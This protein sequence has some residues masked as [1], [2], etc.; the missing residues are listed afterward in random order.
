M[1]KK[2]WI[3]IILA[4]AL[5]V[6]VPLA[7][8]T[9]A[10]ADAAGVLYI[11]T[12]QISDV[13]RGWVDSKDTWEFSPASG[14][15][16]ATL[17][18]NNLTL[19]GTNYHKMSNN[20][21]AY[22]Y[23]T[24][25]NLRIVVNGTCTLGDDSQ[26]KHL[27]D[28][29]ATD[30]NRTTFGIYS[31]GSSPTTRLTITGKTSDSKLVIKTVDYSIRAAFLLV[32]S[33]TKIEAT[34]GIRGIYLGGLT[35][36][37]GSDFSVTSGTR[38]DYSYTVN[39]G[40]ET[41]INTGAKLTVNSKSCY[42]KPYSPIAFRG[43]KVQVNGTLSASCTGQT[44]AS[45]G[46]RGI[47]IKVS[48]FLQIGDGGKVYAK[49]LGKGKNDVSDGEQAIWAKTL[50][51][52]ADGYLYAK[53]NNS[54]YSAVYAKNLNIAKTSNN[55]SYIMTPTHPLH[56]DGNI[57]ESY[58]SKYLATEVEIKGLKQCSLYFR[59]LPS[60]V[61][62]Y[63]YRE[64][65]GTFYYISG[66]GINLSNGAEK[67]V[68]PCDYQFF[69][70]IVVES[71]TQ[72]LTLNNII[73]EPGHTWITVK[74]GATLNLYLSG[75]N[76]IDSGSVPAIRVESGAT[77]NIIGNSDDAA[78][79]LVSSGGT[80]ISNSGTVNISKG[81]LAA[82]KDQSATHADLQGKYNISGG[83]I[84]A[85]INGP[86]TMSGGT[87]NGG[88]TGSAVTLTGGNFN[89]IGDS[90]NFSITDGSGTS[91]YRTRAKLY[92]GTVDSNSSNRT[93]QYIFR[94]DGAAGTETS[95][96]TVRGK[97]LTLPVVSK[98][99]L[100]PGRT[101]GM[102]DFLGVDITG[103]N[104]TGEDI[105]LWLPANTTVSDVT[106]A[107]LAD[108]TFAANRDTPLVTKSDHSA[109]GVLYNRTVLVV[110]GMIAVRGPVGY[111]QLCYGYTGNNSDD[112][113]IDY[114]ENFH[115]TIQKH[116][117]KNVTGVGMTALSGTHI[118]YLDDVNIS[119]PGQRGNVYAGAGLT[120][121][122]SGDST[123]TNEDQDAV[124]KLDG[125]LTLARDGANKT[126]L[127][128]AG[129]KAFA[130]SN[131]GELTVNSGIIKNSCT[132]RRATLKSLTVN[133]GTL[134]GFGQINGTVTI[135]GGSVDIEVPAGTEVKNTDGQTLHKDVLHFDDSL[136]NTLIAN[137]ISFSD[138]SFNFN[139]ND[140]YIDG[141]GN[142]H[143][144][145]P[146]NVTVS[147]ITVGGKTYYPTPGTDG[148]IEMR[149]KC[150][151]IITVPPTDTAV[152]ENTDAVFTLSVIAA[153]VPTYQWQSSTD[154]ENWTDIVGATTSALTLS[155]VTR[156]QNGTT[157]RC[158]VTNSEGS[159]TSAATL[160]V[161]WAPSITTHPENA[162]ALIGE[163]KSFTIALEPGN[164]PA[165]IQWQSSANGTDWNDI[166]GATELSY[167][168][169]PATAQ[170]NGMQYRCVVSNRQDSA[171]S[172]AATLTVHYVPSVTKHP[173]SITVNAGETAS[174]TV[175]IGDGNPPASVQWQSSAN[176]TDWDDISG[177][178]ALSYTTEPTTAQMN[179]TQY[180]CVL[181]TRLLGDTEDRLVISS[182]A[183]LTVHYAPAITQSPS[184]ITVGVG[185]AAMFRVSADANPAPS[186]QWQYSIDGTM[187]QDISG[188][189]ASEYET[190]ATTK[191]MNGWQYRCV[192][193]NPLGTDTSASATLT[194]NYSPEIGGQPQD[195]SVIE[196]E[197]AV[198]TVSDITGNPPPAYQWQVST[199]GETWT[200]L[201]DETGSVYSV[202]TTPSMDGWQYRCKVA[203][204]S[205]S[206][207]SE[208][209]ATLRVT[210]A[211]ANL[212]AEP[213]NTVIL[214]G[215]KLTYTAETN[216]DCQS[217]QWYIAAVSGST[218]E[219]ILNGADGTTVLEYTFDAF[220][221]Y[222]CW[223]T[224]RNSDT[225]F[226]MESNH[227]TMQS[228]L[229]LVIAAI[230]GEMPFLD[231]GTNDWFYNDVAYVWEN[232]LMSGTAADRFSPNASTTRA[233]LV[234]VLYRMDG[235]AISSGNAPF[236]D[237]PAGSWYADAVSWAAENG[238]VTGYSATR[239]APNEPVTREQ[240][241]AI[242]YRY[243][244]LCDR[245]LSPAA[246]LTAFADHASVSG[247][248]REALSWAVGSGLIGGSN[249]RLNPSG[250]ATRAEIAAILHRFLG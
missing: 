116:N 209:P 110:S 176:G 136:K 214:P 68:L 157:Y 193:T 190:P 144:W 170:M 105:T 163:E 158:V 8:C 139:Q 98:L 97:K 67:E 30:T 185:S 2:W 64:T 53:T 27:Y 231:V 86:L 222:E 49:S 71:G 84:H 215:T 112:Q 160:T 35:M 22:I 201:D 236:T 91:L 90:V 131:T 228:G 202:V 172:D 5:A 232:G 89:Y 159:A 148:K 1:K 73:V 246:S 94:L 208:P 182:A 19:N 15:T 241:A 46:C 168:T 178:N 212:T 85:N 78:L 218:R 128:L 210:R 234:T 186:Y 134:F 245:D 81:V 14:N 217:I 63:S 61:N 66:G 203:N 249:G 29:D 6:L 216:V 111:R 183:T 167:T 122:L 187:W 147:T 18:L 56:Q 9:T 225:D 24:I 250:T 238:I 48:N 7:L 125:S 140:L 62:V 57:Y 123:L 42:T 77:L 17:T 117:N 135:N 103:K 45:D 221:T 189:N 37:T 226:L 152:A 219:M 175:E 72:A 166:S 41:L 191:P 52:A 74:S 25:P 247:Y 124:F 180:R 211:Y 199:D 43:E 179:G 196:G 127:T 133:G 40:G 169:E 44:D 213:K 92:Q 207:Y 93:F 141:N 10:S 233:M 20:E 34:S 54:A 130:D 239:F 162:T 26:V 195:V 194:V 149:E 177:A 75:L 108:T 55:V 38:Y 80:A 23:T 198:F 120:L 146:D 76:Y 104:I 184:S 95:K 129:N 174:F 12:L 83:Y 31:G 205:G 82:V 79:T 109:K 119:G 188:A 204:S 70:D 137:G 237:V 242:L 165:S 33:D 156:A 227:V 126:I 59:R 150:A 50:T 224:A 153:P 11:G 69:K 13:S 197:R 96:K 173:E 143:L 88:F 248:A 115:V 138:S 114:D 51:I 151:P 192:V 230:Q 106:I 220:G 145:L 155:S 3:S 171:T 161:H 16:P 142:I 39:C 243:A 102:T 4:L 58:D 87:L 244:K 164:P 60:G 28:K 240:V 65:S 121:N 206:V 181:K 100:Q 101:Y 118:I 36:N 113:W 32:S 99:T 235:S 229:P 47:A 107:G 21:A 223:F 200:D 154:G 132:D